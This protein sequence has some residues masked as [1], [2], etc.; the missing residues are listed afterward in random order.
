MITRT[1]AADPP[2][3][4][5]IRR[6]NRLVDSARLALEENTYFHGRSKLIR[7]DE[8]S[9]GTLVLSGQVPSFYLK[10]ILQ[11]VLSELDGVE[12]IENRVEVRWK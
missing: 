10:Q 12:Q 11:T 2:S 7:I 9:K 8:L 5:P 4:V 6:T 1:D 3:H